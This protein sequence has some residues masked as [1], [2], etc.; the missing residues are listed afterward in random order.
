MKRRHTSVDIGR[1]RFLRGALAS[2]VC[3]GGGLGGL[4]SASAAE[5]FPV[6]PGR[7][8]VHLFLAGG[9]DFRHLLPPAYSSV[10]GSYGR[11]FWERRAR[12]FG[13]ADSAASL[14]RHWSE[15]YLPM[16]HGRTEFG[17]MR[18]CGWLAAQ[19]QQGNVAL[20]CNTAGSDSRDH[21]HGILVMDLGDR[22][23]GK[24]DHGSGWGGRLAYAA[25]AN[26]VAMTQ[27]PRPFALGPDP[28]LPLDPRRNAQDRLIVAS[29][30]RNIAL[31]KVEPGTDWLG[32]EDYVTRALQAYYRGKAAQVPRGSP[33]FRFFE[34]E[35][36]LREFG[37]AIDARL[38][39]LPVPPSL[40]EITDWDGPVRADLGM[41]LRNLHDA[42][43]CAD[44]LNMR[45][46]SLSFDGWDTHDNQAA[47][48]EP[49]LVDLFG[50]NGGLA[51]LYRTLPPR[52]KQ[53]M[54]LV[55]GGEFGRQLNDNGGN[56]T[57]HGYGNVVLLIGAGVRGGVYGN[58]F[59]QAELARIDEPSPDI[60]GLTAL[61]H[62]FGA[63]CEWVSPGSRDYVFPNRVG[64]PLEPGVVPR[65]LFG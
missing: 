18:R 14:Q 37:E 62:V 1:R 20:V 27:S 52:V 4:A 24:F 16:R 15:A 33:Y 21:H 53:Q 58:M 13:I 43:A 31:H 28:A 44:I 5:G 10:R 30:T 45:V 38:A 2:A 55:I 3:V 61:D 11:T 54:V 6:L 59:P 39:D 22:G 8:L 42:L 12:A 19:W 23:A 40:D 56:G 36:K 26:A 51:R 9:P 35:R 63:A 47:Q 7:V 41:Q 29:D 49:M 32:P 50:D 64:A 48:I 17:I 46:A 34:H 60:D 57:D 65:S 25:D